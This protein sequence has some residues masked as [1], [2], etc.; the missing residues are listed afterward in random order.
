MEWKSASP[1]RDTDSHVSA[2]S[3][4]SMSPRL[5][6]A[7]EVRGEVRVSAAEEVPGADDDESHRVLLPVGDAFGFPVC[8]TE[9]TEVGGDVQG[10]IAG[11]DA[12]AVNV[13]ESIRISV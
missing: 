4:D 10:A 1:S 3:V 12:E 8:D 2:P 7:G 11:V 6:A 13:T 9:N 5:Q